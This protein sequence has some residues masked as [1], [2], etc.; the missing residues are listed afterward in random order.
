MNAL[1][2][3]IV[4]PLAGPSYRESDDDYAHVIVQLGDAGRVIVCRDDL[5]WI[6]QHRD[7]KKA[8]RARWASVGYCT[9]RKGLL[10]LCR[11]S[12]AR[13]DPSEWAAL[14]ALP[15]NIAGCARWT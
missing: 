8:G 4:D 13:I 7:G 2:P 6:F 12:G 1:T 11:A 15:G 14:A 9:T 5:Q 3:I 10:R